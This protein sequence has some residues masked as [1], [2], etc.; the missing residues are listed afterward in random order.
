M[1]PAWLLS[2]S[3][4]KGFLLGSLTNTEELYSLFFK[5]T[6]LHQ[7][8]DIFKQYLGERCPQTSVQL[9]PKNHIPN[10]TSWAQCDIIKIPGS[11]YSITFRK[12]DNSMPMGINISCYVW[13]S[14]YF[15]KQDKGSCSLSLL[16]PCEHM[17]LRDMGVNHRVKGKGFMGV[18]LQDNTAAK[19]LRWSSQIKS[20]TVT[21][22][23]YLIV[24]KCMQNDYV[25]R[26]T[27]IYG[28]C[29]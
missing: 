23:Y 20:P 14:N 5:R 22:S 12:Q 24:M 7:M 26:C 15:K 6:R 11:I 3:C 16:L 2:H 9:L 18:C 10:N 28:T 1:S 29:S 13:K 19:I 8:T 27:F 4:Q 17:Q 25:L 21:S